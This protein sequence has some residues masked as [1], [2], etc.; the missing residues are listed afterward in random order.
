MN[1]F[2]RKTLNNLLR[3][4]HFYTK[5]SI[6]YIE[7]DY[8]V[9]LF[10][11]C[12]LEKIP[13]LIF[14]GGTSLSKCYNIINRFSEDVDLSIDCEH[15]SQ[16]N[17]RKSMKSIF[18][19]CDGKI[20]TLVNKNEAS[21]KTHSQFN[22]FIIKY[23]MTYS[24]DAIT[25]EIKVEMSYIQKS[26][27]C[28]KKEVSSIVG[29]YL[30]HINLPFD[31]ATIP[32]DIQ[33]QSLERTFIDKTFA[34]C[35]Y[36]LRDLPIR[37]S[38]HLY[39]LYKIGSLINMDDSF[40]ALVNQ[41]REDRKT[42][43]KCP[44]AQDN[45]DVNKLLNKIIDSNYFKDD[46]EKSTKNLIY[47]NTS[48]DETIDYLKKVI[49]SNAFSSDKNNTNTNEHDITSQFPSNFTLGDFNVLLEI[50]RS[51]EGSTN[52]NIYYELYHNDN[53][54]EINRH[55]EENLMLLFASQCDNI[56]TLVKLFK[57]SGQYLKYKNDTYYEILAETSIKKINAIK[58]KIKKEQEVQNIKKSDFKLIEK[59]HEKDR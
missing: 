48:Y 59:E 12:A 27:P 8:Y 57:T 31:D 44:S 36:Y 16:A 45:Q 19:I 54:K 56:E 47:D 53:H 28:E 5:I 3:A 39:D 6:P 25:P 21:K 50:K 23:P 18:D 38:R 46:Y 58:D 55:S 24:S 7:K 2:D 29:N 9:S 11:R 4:A 51:W 26:F 49:R 42:N 43:E 13:G 20:F 17:K 52:K 14:K 15:F 41:V 37:N 1:L 22:T 34:I 30:K 10:L 35:D 40:V 33:T 32:F